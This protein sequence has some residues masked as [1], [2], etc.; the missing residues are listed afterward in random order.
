MKQILLLLLVLLR[1][2]P[3]EAQTYGYNTGFTL[4]PHAFC[5]TIPIEII[6]D[7]I[8][9]NTTING[10]L[11]RL[12]IDT[13][14][15]QGTVYEGESTRSY[16]ELGNIVSLDANERADTVRVV[17]LPPVTFGHITLTDYVA[18]VMPRPA[19]KTKCD[20]V[21]GFDLINKGVCMKLDL[22]RRMMILSTDK[23]A[24]R[25][26]QGY[27]LKYRL[28]WFVPYVYVSP[29]IRHTDEVL[30][31]L[32]YRQ[33]YTMNKQN[34][35]KHVYK[36]KQVN[37]QVEGFAYGNLSI[38]SYGPEHEDEVAFLNLDRLKWGNFAF[39]DVKAITT[40][41]ASRIGAQILKYGTITI[42]PF[43]KRIIF[44][45]Y[46]GND[47]VT[48]ANK[49]V[50][51][52]YVPQDDMPTV[53]LVRKESAEYKAG[54]RQGDR[55]IRINNEPVTSFE[56]FVAYPFVSGRRYKLHVITRNGM[57]REMYISID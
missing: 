10:R 44:S 47:T 16:R 34:F 30:F 33:L 48:V 2:M 28:K 23:D 1:S 9:L 19:M 35:D 40:Q 22:R 39:T 50:S 55:I 56:Q 12:C 8:Y 42:D 4:S 13:G 25:G 54:L 38:G 3:A 49:Q 36:S 41:G 46:N 32:G 5:D 21:I 51:I 6:D 43:R 53:G 31:D 52:A 7:R 15:S 20:A 26:E 45:P 27:E 17:S 24:F 37:A 14:S 29:F 11:Q 18:S 57:Q